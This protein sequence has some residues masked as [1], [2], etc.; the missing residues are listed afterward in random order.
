MTDRPCTEIGLGALSEPVSP[1]EG[2]PLVVGGGRAD[3]EPVAAAA[4]GEAEEPADGDDQAVLEADEVEDV[5]DQP[6]HPGGE[7]VQSDG[8]EVADPAGAADRR[9]VALVQVAERPDA[10][11]ADACAN[12]L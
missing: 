3:D 11:A 12:E 4:G 10:V 8:V 9:E 7:A 6:G 2:L 5:D 1:V